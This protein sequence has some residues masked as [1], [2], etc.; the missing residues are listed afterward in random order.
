[1]ARK[2]KTPDLD[3]PDADVLAPQVETVRSPTEDPA[4]ASDTSDF[5]SAAT[6]HFNSFEEFYPH[7]IAEHDHADNRRL[8][9][10]GIGLAALCLVNVVL[11]GFFGG[12]W[13]L[14][15]AAIFVFGSAFAG[16]HF[17]QKI[18]PTVQDFPAWSV[19]AQA[20]MFWEVVTRKRPW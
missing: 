17:I 2:P 7:Y 16:D 20:K 10:I 13:S 11:N 5:A 15:W 9:V 14:I 4:P 19:M 18:K 1:M 12:F 6:P 3:T 8:Q